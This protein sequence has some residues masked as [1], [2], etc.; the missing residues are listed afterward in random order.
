MRKRM[1]TETPGDYRKRLKKAIDKIFSEWV[2]RKSGGECFTC[3]VKKRWKDLEAGHY[4]HNKLDFDPM[5]RR[6]Q[7]NR[8]NQHLS[9]NLG[10]YGE[11]LIKEYGTDK[12][13]EM[14][15]RSNQIWKPDTEELEKL[16]EYWQMELSKLRETYVKENHSLVKESVQS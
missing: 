5:N 10:I 13:D 11:K 14:R 6:A 3:G 12:I 9:G 2:R 1:S 8:C 16:L 4:I 7:C 15:L